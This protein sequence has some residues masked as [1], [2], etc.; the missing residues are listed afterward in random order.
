MLPK[1]LDWKRTCLK[2]CLFLLLPKQNLLFSPFY[3]PESNLFLAKI[4][5]LSRS[6]IQKYP[7]VDGNGFGVAIW[8][9]NDT[10]LYLR[11]TRRLINSR[12]VLCRTSLLV[13]L[14]CMGWIGSHSQF[15]A[16]S[17]NKEYTSRSGMRSPEG[18]PSV[19]SLSPS[20]RGHVSSPHHTARFVQL[21]LHFPAQI[22]AAEQGWH[23]IKQC[24]RKER[25]TTGD[26]QGAKSWNG[27]QGKMWY[28]PPPPSQDLKSMLV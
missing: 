3:C 9:Q 19:S 22:V 27:C 21:C 20:P 26:S 4:I 24:N 13:L 18:R 16:G 7:L 10:G 8:A 15:I 23:L 1:T 6:E 14:I 2:C 28:Y 12:T 25:L 17:G 5:E 11:P